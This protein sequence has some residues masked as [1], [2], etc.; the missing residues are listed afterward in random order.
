MPTKLLEMLFLTPLIVLIGIECV[1]AIYRG[2]SPLSVD[3]VRIY[4]WVFKSWL[5]AK[6]YVAPQTII[7]DQDIAIGN[8]I[9]E[10]LPNTI[11]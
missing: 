3:F 7:T 6:G 1:C 10:V 5:E 8:A 9:A 2:E 4:L 11:H